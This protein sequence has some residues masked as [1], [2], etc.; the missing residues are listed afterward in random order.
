[1]IIKVLAATLVWLLLMCSAKSEACERIDD[2]IANQSLE[3]FVEATTC[4]VNLMR[5]NADRSSLRPESHLAVSATAHTADLVANNYFSHTGLDGSTPGIRDQRAGYMSMATSW[6][7]GENLVSYAATPR[8]VVDAW[9]ASP[10]HNYV[11]YLDKW[12][13]LGVGATVQKQCECLMVA[14]EFGV[15]YKK[16]EHPKRRK[17]KR[18]RR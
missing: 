17:L 16:R 9:I 13:D 6:Q 4:Q 2:T 11:L 14:A 18:K 3:S 12:K 5:T 10:A 7:I 15:K 8:V 1:M